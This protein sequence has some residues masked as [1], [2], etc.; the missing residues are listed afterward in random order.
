ML[1]TLLQQSA[2]GRDAAAAGPAR[3]RTSRSASS[4]S[5]RST[6]RSSARSAAAA[7]TSR[8][9]LR[10]LPHDRHRAVP[11]GVASAR[12]SSRRRG[13][14]ALALGAQGDAQGRCD[15]I[16]S[17]RLARPRAAGARARSAPGGGLA[18]QGRGPCSKLLRRS[19]DQ[20]ADRG[21]RPGY[22]RR[23]DRDPA[24]GGDDRSAPVQRQRVLH[25]GARLTSA[26]SLRATAWT[27]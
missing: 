19:Q 4:R 16:L 5:S 12:R 9:R 6:V 10:T 2:T 7:R 1:S 3:T 11:R 24:S 8:R 21:V 20:P 17:D 14:G 27:S 13:A 18:N 25:Q 26:T 15:C 22:W 23:R